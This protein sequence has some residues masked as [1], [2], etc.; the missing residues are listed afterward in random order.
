MEIN[1]QF[2]V[3]APIDVA[4]RTLTDVET[5]AP[6]IP[7]FQLQEIEG[8]EY[9]GVMKLK[10]GAVVMSYASHVT[11]V[12]RDDAAKRV[13][14]RGGGREQRGQGT[15]EATIRSS[16]TAAGDETQVD[17][18]ALLNVTGRVAG[19]GRGIMADVST[20]LIDQFVRCLESRILVPASGS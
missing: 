6:C 3:K 7:G 2:R 8:E 19:F 20:R 18:E 15:V 10:V 17:M 11:F 12:E 9:R 5:I 1:N 13:V 16:L 4:W 14:M